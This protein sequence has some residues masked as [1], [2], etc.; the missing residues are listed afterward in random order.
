M[1]KQI[2]RNNW[3]EILQ[4]SNIFNF[5]IS[6]QPTAPGKS[7]TSNINN[8]NFTIHLH[9]MQ[10]YY[11]SHPLDQYLH[12]MGC[13]RRGRALIP[14]DAPQNKHLLSHKLA[15]KTPKYLFGQITLNLLTIPLLINLVI[16][17]ISNW[18][19]SPDTPLN[20]FCYSC[21]PLIH[22][23]RD[24]FLTK[25]TLSINIWWKTCSLQKTQV[26]R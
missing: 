26:A 10:I 4:I 5:Q 23:G 20:I 16:N 6:T 8:T 18:L 1:R 19:I 17:Y 22:I 24:L 25:Y 9:G 15:I 21:L 2:I 12:G 14:S 7:V 11:Q 3:P 13:G